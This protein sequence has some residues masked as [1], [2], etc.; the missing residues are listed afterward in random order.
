MRYEMPFPDATTPEALSGVILQAEET[1]RGDAPRRRRA[2]AGRRVQVAYRQL[3][4]TPEWDQ[5][6]LEAIPENIREVARRNVV[7]ARA[8]LELID[9]EQLP[10]E[11]PAWRIVA[12]NHPQELTGYYREAATAVGIDWELLASIN[13]VETRMGRIRGTSTAGAQ[14]PMQFIPTSWEIYGEGGDVNDDRD[15]IFAAAR[16]LVDR[17]GDRFD[18][19]RALRGYNNHPAYV[20]AVK[21]YA[22]NIADHP[23]AYLGYHA[24]QVYFTTEEGVF[25][26]PVGYHETEP[27]PVEEYLDR[28]V[29]EP[30]R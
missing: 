30:A 7:A 25:W 26:L 5:E 8:L 21:A 14:G 16:H 18:V 28:P 22:N 20:E 29:A 24:W 12:P 9:D 10:T 1:L 13:L 2:Q 4:T 11:L 17:A 23:G 3:A 15:A 27:V 6:V 19:D